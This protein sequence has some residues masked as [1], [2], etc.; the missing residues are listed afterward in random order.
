M[1]T[2][3]QHLEPFP[4]RVPARGG[5]HPGDARGELICGLGR[6]WGFFANAGPAVARAKPFCM[7][8][9]PSSH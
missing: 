2:G 5:V 1:K 8:A 4:R 3:N 9:A 6:H 7:G